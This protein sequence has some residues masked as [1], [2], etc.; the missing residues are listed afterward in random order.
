[1]FRVFIPVGALTLLVS[2][3]LLIVASFVVASF[4]TLQMDP[5]VYLQ[6]EGGAVTIVLVLVSILA[7]L[8][9]QDLY[10]DI[11]LK[12]GIVLLH[13]LCLAIGIAFLAQGLISYL[14]HTLRMP[15]HMMVVGSFISMITIFLWRLAFCAYALPVVGREQ[16][17]M[18]GG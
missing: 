15:A 10:S 7:G 14:F 17:L 16:I 9:F 11:Y 6:Y 1:L 18:V 8:Y 3:V 2:E 13:Q 4:L 12:S 5:G